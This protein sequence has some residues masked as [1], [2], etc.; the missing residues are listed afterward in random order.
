[1]KATLKNI[2]YAL[3]L[4]LTIPSCSKDDDK[5][6]EP[7]EEETPATIYI[8]GYS[9]E[10]EN[11]GEVIW[12]NGSPLQVY[13]T[14]LLPSGNVRYADAVYDLD[15]VNN[16]VYAVWK[17]SHKALS[18]T[19]PTAHIYLW[20]NDQ[21][22]PVV[23]NDYNIYPKAIDKH[24]DD[25]YF[26]G[27]YTASQQYPS[28]WKNGSREQLSGGFGVVNDLLVTNADVLAVGYVSV[29]VQDAATLWKNGVLTKLSEGHGYVA[30]AV[31]Q[32]ENNTYVVGEGNING[33]NNPRSAL[34]W[35]NDT[36]QILALPTGQIG[37]SANAVALA[38]N[39]VYVAGY[40][41]SA[42][43]NSE[44]AIV[45]IDGSPLQLSTVLSNA[46]SVA[47][48]GN[49]IYAC[50]YE[51]PGTKQIAVMWKIKGG[52]VETVKLSQ[53]AEDAAAY[54]IKIK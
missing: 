4:L 33:V 53:G 34:L 44:R 48:K 35:K 26:A 6:I 25:L 7:I 16:D 23:E 28:I 12:R 17:L 10:I 1:M 27:Y 30:N 51:K 22:T 41:Y 37:A 50:G 40:A 47:V 15:I 49:T 29:G 8:S 2:S 9:N 31:A 14:G 13:K 46:H 24:G 18:A 20:K 39:K 52:N 3:V 45:W 32:T 21:N 11:M 43:S 5:I 42:Q 36:R 38:D 19:Y 54:C